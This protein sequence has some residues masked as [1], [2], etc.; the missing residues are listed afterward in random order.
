LRYFAYLLA[1]FVSPVFAGNLVLNWI[2]PTTYSDNLTPLPAGTVLQY[3]AYG[4][5]QGQPL[6]LV[7]GM[8]I[9]ATTSTRTNV[10]PGVLC[11]AVTALL[12][13]V[14]SAQTSPICATGTPLA[15]TTATP[16]GGLTVAPVTTSTIA[17]MLV[18]GKDT[19]S[20]LIVGSIALG[21]PCTSKQILTYNVIPAASVTLNPPYRNIPALLGQCQ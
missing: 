16:P 12:N 11:Y 8:P 19:Y 2:A 20:V 6:V 7:P 4:A 14:E 10:N 18:P 3:N 15:P 17:Y 13:G 5:A 1:L 9:T 21:V